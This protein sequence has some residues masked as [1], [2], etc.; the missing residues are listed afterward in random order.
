MSHK[1]DPTN[2]NADYCLKVICTG[3]WL[4]LACKNNYQYYTLW[5]LHGNDSALLSCIWHMYTKSHN[6][7]QIHTLFHRKIL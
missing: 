5:V 2:P 6:L 1:P 4:G 7:N 3:G